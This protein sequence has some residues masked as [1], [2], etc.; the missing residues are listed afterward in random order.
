[1]KTDQVFFEF[2]VEVSILMDLEKRGINLD[3]TASEYA[4]AVISSKLN[5]PLDLSDFINEK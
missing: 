5:Q 2:E 1:M 3:F 4:Q